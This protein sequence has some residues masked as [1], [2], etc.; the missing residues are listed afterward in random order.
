MAGLAPLAL[1][2]GDKTGER[3]IKGGRGH[4]RIGLYFAALTAAR[5]NP[6]LSIVYKRL[7]ANGKE[8]KI[9]LTALMRK[10]VV[11]ANALIH[12]DRLWTPTC[13]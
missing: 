1:D 13:P 7:I 11:L 10:L 9:A 12:Q 5:Y 6:H 8:A 4:V 2:S 3:H